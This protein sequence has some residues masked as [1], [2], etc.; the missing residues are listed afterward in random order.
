[1]ILEFTANFVSLSAGGHPL[2]LEAM[3]REPRDDYIVLIVFL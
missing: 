1:M 2:K 3:S